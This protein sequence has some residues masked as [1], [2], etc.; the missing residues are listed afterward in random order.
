[1]NKLIITIALMA[2]SQAAMSEEKNTLERA[3]EVVQQMRDAA[4][5]E[6]A[7]GVSERNELHQWPDAAAAVKRIQVRYNLLKKIQ[8][9]GQSNYDYYVRHI[10]WCWWY[11]PCEEDHMIA[12]YWKVLR[13][14]SYRHLTVAETWIKPKGVTMLDELTRA[15]YHLKLV[16]EEKEWALL[17]KG[18]VDRSFSDHGYKPWAALTVNTVN[19]DI[20]KAESAVTR[21][22]NR[23][24]AVS[25][26]SL[27]KIRQSKY[28]QADTYLRRQRSIY[29][30][31]Q[32]AIAWGK[33][34]EKERELEREK[35]AREAEK[36]AREAEQ[37]IVDRENEFLQSMMNML[38]GTEQGGSE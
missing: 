33:E 9:N 10:G 13:D 11:R 32:D 8:A 7:K 29:K 31:E 2:L 5:K 27:D 21:A 16:K 24:D 20:V 22:D 25:D 3:Q 34:K 37:A 30:A 4:D 19:A 15:K 18:L 28:E 36:A 23:V 26:K 12:N 17:Y 14:N 1:M 6:Y 35:A 38:Y